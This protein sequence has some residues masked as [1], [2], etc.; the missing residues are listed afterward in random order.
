MPLF[1]LLNLLVDHAGYKDEDEAMA[2]D[3][4]RLQHHHGSGVG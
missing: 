3:D 1:F 4:D 2:G